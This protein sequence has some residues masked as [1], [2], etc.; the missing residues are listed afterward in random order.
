MHRVLFLSFVLLSVF[1]V[2]QSSPADYRPKTT[3][4]PLNRFSDIGFAISQHIRKFD[5]MLSKAFKTFL[6]SDAI[7]KDSIQDLLTFTTNKLDYELKPEHHI[8]EMIINITKS[9]I[10]ELRTQNESEEVTLETTSKRSLE[11]IVCYKGNPTLVEYKTRECH[12]Y[13]RIYKAL[14]SFIDNQ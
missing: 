1:T 7:H 6:M 9:N 5:I 10:E 12:R 4:P 14:I 8:S 11:E 2:I 13:P 3:S